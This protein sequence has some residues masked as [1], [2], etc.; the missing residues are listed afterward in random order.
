MDTPLDNILGEK[1]KR[2]IMQDIVSR[3][4]DNVS[5]SARV[6][7]AEKDT[8]SAEKVIDDIDNKLKSIQVANM[9][10]GQ[11]SFSSRCSVCTNPAVTTINVMLNDKNIAYSQIESWL[12]KEG[13][14]PTSKAALRNHKKKHLDAD[15]ANVRRSV[16]TSN[17]MSI[18]SGTNELIQNKKLDLDTLLRTLI[19]R[20]N[21]YLTVAEMTGDNSY[22]KSLSS[23]VSEIRKILELQAKL[24]GEYD[25]NRKTSDTNVMIIINDFINVVSETIFA[26]APDKSSEF[27]E[28]FR[29]KYQKWR[30][31]A[32]RS[33]SKED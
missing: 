5:A 4:A 15:I 12:E 17:L 28:V 6:I 25:K 18:E 3:A 32:Q 30:E 7:A 19:L 29:D 31:N 23:T 26:V 33:I 8:E 1:I 21:Q 9:P 22:A 20:L 14:P 10:S 13:Y 11:M 2:G 24:S 16:T 27:A